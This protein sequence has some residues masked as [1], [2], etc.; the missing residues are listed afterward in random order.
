MPHLSLILITLLTTALLSGCSTLESWQS[1]AEE[2]M[3]S[4]NS[5]LNTNLKAEPAAGTGYVPMEELAKNP[6]LPFDKAWIKQGA[7][8][9]RYHTT[10]YRPGEHRIPQ[11]G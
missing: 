11:T 10:V 9:N 2:S 8:Y 4:M 5:W 1:D 7:D 6:N 3:D